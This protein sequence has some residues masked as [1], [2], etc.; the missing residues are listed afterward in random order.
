MT[1]GSGSRMGRRQVLLGG[2]A[3]PLALGAG[4]CGYLLHPERRGA[5]GGVIDGTVLIIDLLWLLPGI[6]PGVICLIVDFTTGCI[7]GGP[8]RITISRTPPPGEEDRR[9]TTASVAIDG[10]VAASAGVQP[11]RSARLS[12][13]QVVDGAALRSRGRLVVQRADG[14]RAEAFVRDLI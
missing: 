10:A 2:A 4:G 12:W 13:T 8:S 7:Y 6:L 5:R 11:D 3:L 1:N 9:I 14:A